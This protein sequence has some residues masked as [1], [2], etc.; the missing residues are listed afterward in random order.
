MMINAQ[1]AFS[2]SRLRA[3]LTFRKNL[4]HP[5]RSTSVGCFDNE[6]FSSALIDH[7]SPHS[8]IRALLL[9]KF[10]FFGK[11]REEF[12]VSSSL[13]K[14]TMNQNV[15]SKP[16][17]GWE[18]ESK[19]WKIDAEAKHRKI[20][21]IY[22]NCKGA[23]K[24]ILIKFC[25]VWRQFSWNSRVNRNRVQVASCAAS[26]AMIHLPS[27]HF[28]VNARDD[29]LADCGFEILIRC[30][31]FDDSA[32]SIVSQTVALN[33]F[34]EQ[35]CLCWWSEPLLTVLRTNNRVREMKN[36]WV[37]VKQWAQTVRNICSD[38][39]FHWKFID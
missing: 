29:E 17:A 33:N 4:D 39:E 5:P 31:S 13:T 2:W 30:L 27:Q 36:S 3:T 7:L 16:L 20:I 32:L 15:I 14:S 1:N 37:A 10:K 22:R 19:I 8:L 25:I 35:N 23:P 24:D 18:G 6:H 9:A 38:Q 11:P 12:F 28:F 21:G 34:S 26:L